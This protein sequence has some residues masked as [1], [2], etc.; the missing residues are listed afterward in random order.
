MILPTI[1]SPNGIHQ[2]FLFHLK[3]K[4]IAILE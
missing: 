3:K 2:L 1:S 4:F